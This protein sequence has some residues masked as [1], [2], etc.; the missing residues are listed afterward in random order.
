MKEAEEFY[1]LRVQ[2]Y[3]KAVDS[4]LIKAPASGVVIY[5]TDWRNEKKRVG[6]SVRVHDSILAIPDLSTLLIEGHVSEIDA[7]KV[8]VGGEVRVTLDAIPNQAFTGRI[9]E[10]S[11]VFRPASFDRPTKVFEFQVKLNRVDPKRMR[12][13]MAVRLQLIAD[14]LENVHSVP[15]SALYREDGN[16]YLWAQEKGKALRRRVKVGKDNG[17]VAVI[18]SGLEEGDQ[19]ASRPLM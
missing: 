18:E 14:Q 5:R 17:M 6:S 19:V 11:S 16:S 2:V 12:P 13:G 4:L 1:R 7:G 9:V 3:R 15:L 10:T 8:K